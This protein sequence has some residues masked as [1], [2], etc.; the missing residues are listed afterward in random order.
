MTEANPSALLSHTIDSF[1]MQQDNEQKIGL[2]VLRTLPHKNNH[3]PVLY[4]GSTSSF[5]S[6]EA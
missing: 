4:L 3:L 2:L 6:Y 5:A 1:A